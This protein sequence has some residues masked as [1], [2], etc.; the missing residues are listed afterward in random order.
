M[1]TISLCVFILGLNG[2]GTGW[3]RN[4]HLHQCALESMKMNLTIIIN[5]TALRLYTCN[6]ETERNHMQNQNEYIDLQ[7]SSMAKF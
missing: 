1:I 6:V 3:D 5:T 4:F 2:F 7:L